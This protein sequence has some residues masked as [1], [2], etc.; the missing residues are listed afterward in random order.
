MIDLLTRIIGRDLSWRFGR[1]LYMAARGEGLNDMA[2]NGERELIVRAARAWA[3]V[4]PGAPAIV[5]DCGANLGDWTA[6]ALDAFAAENIAS[7]FHALEPTP[8]SRAALDARFGNHQA[9]SVHPIALSDFDGSAAFRIVSETGGT[10]GL[11][12]ADGDGDTI[13]VPVQRAEVWAAANGVST[14]ALMKIDTEGHDYGVIAGLGALLAEQAVGV[15]QFEYNHR[16]LETRRSLRD[17][18]AL[19]AANG[20]RVGRANRHGI[21]VYADWNPENDR[22]FEWNYLLIAP[23]M[24]GALDVQMVGWGPSNTLVPA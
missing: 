13:T 24:L 19:A 21:D 3:R 16:W 18:F 8:G 14:I 17:I 5:V 10:N 2:A 6:M 7:T 11:A 23:D 15:I 22:F 20:Y 1:A 12:G 4:H 9:V